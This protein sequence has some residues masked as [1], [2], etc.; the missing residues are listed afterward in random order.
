MSRVEYKEA[1]DDVTGKIKIEED[2]VIKYG[3]QLK[4]SNDIVFS[5]SNIINYHIN[6]KNDLVKKI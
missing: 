1:K 3:G 6:P 5:S 2:L 4:F